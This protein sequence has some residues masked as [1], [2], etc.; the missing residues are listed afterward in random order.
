MASLHLC[1]FNFPAR[2]LSP[3][4]FETPT[5]GGSTVHAHHGLST[6]RSHLSRLYV[7]ILTPI[8]A[9]AMSEVSDTHA[10]RI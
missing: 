7:N 6:A 5:V 8:G 10:G 3:F 9:G 2:F 1:S 4:H